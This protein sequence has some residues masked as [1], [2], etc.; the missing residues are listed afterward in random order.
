MSRLWRTNKR[1]NEQWKVEQYSVW[2]ESAIHLHDK[3]QIVVFSLINTTQLLQSS[4][5]WL[6]LITQKHGWE[7]RLHHLT[8]L[9]SSSRLAFLQQQNTQPDQPFPRQHQGSQT[10]LKRSGLWTRRHRRGCAVKTVAQLWRLSRQT[11]QRNRVNVCYAIE[12]REPGSERVWKCWWPSDSVHVSAHVSVPVS[13][14]APVLAFVHASV[15][16]RAVEEAKAVSVKAIQ[17][18]WRL[19]GS[20][21]INLWS[22]VASLAMSPNIW[23]LY[24][25]MAG[26]LEVAWQ[27]KWW[28]L[29]SWR[30]PC[31]FFLLNCKKWLFPFSP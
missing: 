25:P 27:N 26:T 18:T 30:C 20:F 7:H 2:A 9:W 8:W 3:R 6:D 15:L 22:I 11:G 31:T 24:L 16:L 12:V 13:A 10:V 4:K 28:I 17:L 14:S 1:T 29:H 23:Q 5:E 19:V 21:K